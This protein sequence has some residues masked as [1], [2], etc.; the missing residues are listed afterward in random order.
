LKELDNGIGEKMSLLKMLVIKCDE[1]DQNYNRLRNYINFGELEN[2]DRILCDLQAQNGSS[3]QDVQNEISDG[4][5]LH[6]ICGNLTQ[7][8][9]KELN[10]AR[11]TGRNQAHVINEAVD[12]AR[13]RGGR[14]NSPLRSAL[15]GSNGGAVRRDLSES[16]A[17]QNNDKVE[18]LQ[19]Q[20]MDI[21]AEND[22]LQHEANNMVA[23]YTR[24]LE[25]Q[26]DTIKS[27]GQRLEHAGN[28]R[29]TDYEGIYRREN[30]ALKTENKML[31]DKVGDLAAGERQ[32]SSAIDALESENRRLRA[33][34]EDKEREFS[35]QNDQMRQ[36]LIERDGSSTKQK[37]EWADIYGNMKR[38]TDG[39][40][41]DIRMLNKENERL[42]K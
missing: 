39:L 33:D 1:A 17:R 5:N 27:L 37:N 38:E 32:P 2:A 6:Q 22:R 42:V 9:N 20:L 12:D 35:R 16:F 23:N 34:L 4:A 28:D 11:Q 26:D 40:K 30:E 3:L 31:R 36:L 10:R 18:Q 14:S 41:R 19:R 13:G 29:E 21:Q 24:K 7:M 8:I 25:A 15:K